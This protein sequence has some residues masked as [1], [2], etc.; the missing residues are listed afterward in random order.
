MSSILQITEAAAEEKQTER[1]VEMAKWRVKREGRA[2][3]SHAE[4]KEND[5]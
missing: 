5:E 4:R 3:I 1:R 2:A